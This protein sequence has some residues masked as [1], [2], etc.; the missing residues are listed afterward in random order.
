V[1]LVGKW[2]R[3][4]KNEGYLGG[5]GPI[6]HQKNGLSAQAWQGITWAKKSVHG[7]QN[8][9]ISFANLSKRID[10]DEWPFESMP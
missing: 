7:P 3:F 2:T 8:F 10:S 6:L 1:D 9:R 5:G 4:R